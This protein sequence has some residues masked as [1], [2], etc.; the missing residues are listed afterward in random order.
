MVPQNPE[1][2]PCGGPLLPD[3]SAVCVPYG[4]TCDGIWHCVDG[5]DEEEKF[6]ALRQCRPEYFQCFNN[7]LDCHFQHL[8]HDLE[9]PMSVNISLE[10]YQQMREERGQVRRQQ[11]LR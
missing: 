10:L 8:V 1:D 5:S 4:V 2:F 7:R 6:C 11:R 3:G 9:V